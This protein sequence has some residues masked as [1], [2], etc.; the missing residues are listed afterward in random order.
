[1]RAAGLRAAAFDGPGHGVSPERQ[2]TIR[3][4]GESVGAVLDTLDRVRIVIAHSIG[5]IA[6]VAALGSRDGVQ[7]DGLVLLAPACSLGEAL[8]RWAAD[9]LRRAPGVKGRVAEELAR[10]NDIPVSHWDLRTLGVG[11][12][13]PVL[14][15]HDPADDVV[16]FREAETVA[17]AVP[18]AR[19]VPA[20]DTGHLGILRAPLVKDAL[21][22]FIAQTCR[23][24]EVRQ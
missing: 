8:D 11:L 13:L 2:A 7:P 10:R 9:H 19:L 1:V 20:P 22:D 23:G 5:A 15:I 24:K 12:G 16:P 3:Q 17:E 6:A 18:G 4:Y 14:V 21:G